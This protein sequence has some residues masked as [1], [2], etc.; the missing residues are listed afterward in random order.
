MQSGT[1]PN[2]NNAVLENPKANRNANKSPYIQ[3]KSTKTN[4]LDFFFFFFL[5]T[6]YLRSEIMALFKM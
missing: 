4:K 3:R 2:N 5:F 6:L 1:N